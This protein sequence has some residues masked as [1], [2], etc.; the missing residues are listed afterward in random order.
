MATKFRS[1]GVDLDSI[2]APR[3]VNTARANVG[4]R[5]GGVD[6][7]QRF[8]ASTGGDNPPSNTGYRSGGTDLR[9]LFRSISF[10]PITTTLT[11]ST[12]VASGGGGGG[13]W[14][15]SATAVDGLAFI[16]FHVLG[17]GSALTPAAGTFYSGSASWGSPFGSPDMSSTPGNYT[18]YMYAQDVNGITSQ[19]NLPVTVV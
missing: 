3:G 13:S 19:T 9:F 10:N 16:A 7:A 2:F 11:G 17:Y 15:F 18:F 12:S 6:L 4:Y 8:K 14:S 5:V 1:S